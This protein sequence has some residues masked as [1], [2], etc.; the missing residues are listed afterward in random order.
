MQ[1]YC[2]NDLEYRIQASNFNTTG[3][4]SIVL[5]VAS[6]RASICRTTPT[7]TNQQ[8]GGGPHLGDLPYWNKKKQRR[9]IGDDQD[10][11]QWYLE[12]ETE[13]NFPS[14][15]LQYW[16]DHLDDIHQKGFVKMALDIVGIPAMSADPERL[17][18]R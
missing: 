13:N 1:M 10:E 17:F 3:G 16:I 4:D 11:L 5:P 12:P 14:C 9:G 18:C 15:L 8:S 2:R 6:A 7:S